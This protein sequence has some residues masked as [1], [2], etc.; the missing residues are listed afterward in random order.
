MKNVFRTIAIVV[1]SESINLSIFPLLYLLVFYIP[2]VS[3]MNDAPIW[4]SK[5]VS[6]YSNQDLAGRR[7]AISPTLFRTTNVEGKKQKTSDILKELRYKHAIL[8]PRKQTKKTSYSKKENGGPIRDWFPDVSWPIS[9]PLAHPS[10]S[11]T[12]SSTTDVLD[13]SSPTFED[14]VNTIVPTEITRFPSATPTTFMPTVI[15]DVP[16]GYQP[17]SS[18]RPTATPSLTPVPTTE[19][20]PTMPPSKAA[21]PTGSPLS[22]SPS[23]STSGLP[24][25]QT[26]SVPSDTPSLTPSSIPMAPINTVTD[27]PS[28]TDGADQISDAPV[29]ATGTESPTNHPASDST[30]PAAL[31][32]GPPLSPSPS[33]SP[34]IWSTVIPSESPSNQSTASPSESSRNQPTNETSES[35]S[36]QPIVKPSESPSDKPTVSPSESPS[37]QPTLDPSESP[38]DKPT[39]K[40]S[41]SPTNQPTV[42][43]SESP[44]NQPT[45]NPSELPSNHPTVKTSESPSIQPTVSPS[46]S[47]SI[48]PTVSPSESPSI[49]PTIGPTESPSIQPT[50]KPSTVASDV[51]SLP[52]STTTSMP[53]TKAAS[54][55][56]TSNAPTVAIGTESPSSMENTNPPDDSVAN[57][58]SLNGFELSLKPKQDRSTR[59]NAIDTDDLEPTIAAAMGSFFFSEFHSTW[60]NLQSIQLSVQA[61]SD[62]TFGKNTTTSN[63]TRKSRRLSHDSHLTDDR[64]LLGSWIFVVSIGIASF[65]ATTTTIPTSIEID[66]SQKNALDQTLAI[67]SLFEEWNIPWTIYNVTMI[68]QFASSSSPPPSQMDENSSGTNAQVTVLVPTAFCVLIISMIFLWAQS[69]YRK[70]RRGGFPRFATST[71]VMTKN[72]TSE[73]S[74]DE[75]EITGSQEGPTTIFQS[76]TTTTTPEADED[77]DDEDDDDEEIEIHFR[78]SKDHEEQREMVLF[79]DLDE[80]VWEISSSSSNPTD[81]TTN[82]HDSDRSDSENNL[83]NRELSIIEEQS[84]SSEHFEEA[85]QYSHEQYGNDDEDEVD[86]D[87]KSTQ[88]KPMGSTSTRKKTSTIASITIPGFKPSPNT[89]MTR[90]DEVKRTESTTATTN[91]T[92]PPTK[93]S[94]KPAPSKKANSSSAN[95]QYQNHFLTW[96]SLV[97]ASY[98]AHASPEKDSIY[99]S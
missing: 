76:P 42:N 22:P 84:E 15:T 31:P 92:T 7:L 63:D 38:S 8:M 57:K 25:A 98:L 67:D 44:S 37:N 33:E 87:A 12:P 53:P 70:R 93:S 5:G 3:S 90:V 66:L 99:E 60:N 23:E 49:Q 71:S 61:R 62:G 88:H 43:P 20:V 13:T 51:P 18:S 82:S 78:Y 59:G 50:T 77:D 47:P 52:P 55:Y 64:R 95:Q 75:P 46:E 34:S 2:L 30:N 81:E 24:T 68:G 39:V 21:L 94:L 97:E 80:F 35:P 40:T 86:A 73:A 36:N 29:V 4:I 83:P 11:M 45:V 58:R 1:K 16:T 85:L 56:P 91:T 89:A 17:L 19:S 79:E 9:E 6:S 26:S 54:H 27:R 74:H 32:T 41:E 28:I 72:S 48:Q 96:D 14:V 69:H 65:D 10:P